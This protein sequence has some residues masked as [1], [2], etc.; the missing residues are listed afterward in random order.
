MKMQQLA[1]R[2]ASKRRIGLN[3]TSDGSDGVEDVTQR[4]YG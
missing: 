4:L 1:K 2:E 3:G